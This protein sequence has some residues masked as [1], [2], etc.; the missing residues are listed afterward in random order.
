MLSPL[1]LKACF[2]SLTL[3]WKYGASEGC[4]SQ[5]KQTKDIIFNHYWGD[6]SNPV[7]SSLAS[8]HNGISDW[9]LAIIELQH[10]QMQFR[11]IF[12]FTDTKTKNSGICSTDIL[13]LITEYFQF[14]V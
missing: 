11:I 3:Y 12:L 10:M 14:K 1:I 9:K 4:K 8:N 2:M 5:L 13:V 6:S 7:I